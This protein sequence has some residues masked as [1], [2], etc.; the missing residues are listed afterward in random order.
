MCFTSTQTPLLHVYIKMTQRKQPQ[1]FSSK[2]GG[3]TQLLHVYVKMTQRKQ[4]QRFSSKYGGQTQSS[5]FNTVLHCRCI[6][7]KSDTDNFQLTI[8]KRH[9]Q[10]PRRLWH[11]GLWT[12][13]FTVHPKP[14][15]SHGTIIDVSKPPLYASTT[16]FNF[17]QVYIEDVIVELL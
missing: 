14:H 17:P 6:V 16:F 4:P 11:T 15:R 2:Y 8:L 10:R 7:S 1:R 12:F 9:Q 13:S 5:G 3:Q